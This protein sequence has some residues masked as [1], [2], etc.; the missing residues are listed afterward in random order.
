MQQIMNAAV[1][2]NRKVSVVGRSMI[3]VLAVSQ[4]LGY[5]EVPEGTIIDIDK[6]NNYNPEELLIITTGTQ[7]EPMSALSRMSAGEHKKVQ[8]TPD[9]LVI[10]SSS[11]IP[12]NEKSIDKVIDELEK[13]GAEVI[14]NQLADVHVSGHACKEELKLMLSLVK[15]KYFMPVHGEYRF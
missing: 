3:N 7:G 14:Y 6:I 15:P 11:A 12:G 4:E 5:L 2:C 8:I 1:K 13:L 9:D 10:F